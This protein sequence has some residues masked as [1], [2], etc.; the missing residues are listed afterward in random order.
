MGYAYTYPDD[1]SPLFDGLI[2]GQRDLA[3]SVLADETGAD[4]ADLIDALDASDADKR[5]LH[6][7][8]GGGR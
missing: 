4:L 6:A 3:R 2:P 8:I 5:A 1:H 7:A